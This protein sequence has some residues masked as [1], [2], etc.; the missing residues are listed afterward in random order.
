MIAFSSLEG[1][2]QDTLYAV[3]ILR[4]HPAFTAVAV[5]TLAL[6]I[7]ANTAVFS[8][9]NGVLLAPLEYRNPDRLVMEW[10]NNPD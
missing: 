4:K 10:E 7:G 5:L 3:R 6:G 9:V 2:W 1:L 8:I